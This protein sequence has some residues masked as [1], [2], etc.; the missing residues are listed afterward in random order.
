ML[1]DIQKTEVNA[2]TVV[3][4]CTAFL[5]AKIMMALM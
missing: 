5:I 3:L 1:L 2:M 4:C